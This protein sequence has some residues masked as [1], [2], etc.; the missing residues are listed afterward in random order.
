[1]RFSGMICAA[2]MLVAAM[3]AQACE[4]YVQASAAEM[5]VAEVPVAVAPAIDLSAATAKKPAKKTA[6]KTKEKVEYMRAAN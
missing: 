4:R 5:I 6:K 1:M 2:A 3:P